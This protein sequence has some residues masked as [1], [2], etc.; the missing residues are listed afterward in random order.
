MKN[1]ELFKL[2]EGL[3][4]VEDLETSIPVKEGYKVVCNKK[5][6]KDHLEAFEEMKNSIIKKYA[7][8]DGEV[9]FDNPDRG[10]CVSELNELANQE[11]EPIEFK[12]IKL[13]AI[14]S[15]E[16]PMKAISAMA[17]MIEEA[18]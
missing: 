5:I 3:E 12:K 10:K 6:I 8:K 2:L 4:K 14:D 13:S 18:E 7:D 16:L 9:K 17:F 15:L 1:Y 11:V